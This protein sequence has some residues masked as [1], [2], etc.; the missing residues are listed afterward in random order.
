MSARRSSI[1][2]ALNPLWAKSPVVLLRFPGLLMSLTAGTMLL[3]LA[4]GSYPLFISSTSSEALDRQIESVTVF[5]AG[6]SVQ[7]D[8]LLV[9]SRA[10]YG[11]IVT[12]PAALEQYRERERA[13]AAEVAASPHL[14]PVVSSWRAPVVNGVPIGEGGRPGATR[15]FRPLYR[16]DALDHVV[17]VTGREGDGVWMADLAARDLGIRPGDELRLTAFGVENEVTVT[18]DGIYEALFN[19]ALTPYW[20]SHVQDIYPPDP[21]APAPP[22]LLLG[23]L[24]TIIH[25]SSKLSAESVVQR[26]EVPIEPGGSITLDDARDVESLSR[27]FQ[28]N[29]RDETT[30]L[31]SAF[32]FECFGGGPD[33]SSFISAIVASTEKRVA[34]V[35]GPVRLLLVAGVL[36][37]IVVVAAAGAFAVAARRVEADLLFVRG[38]SPGTM[39]MK[40]VAEAV[41]P[42]VIG[43]AA[44]FGIALGLVQTLGPGGPVDENAVTVA[45]QA[46]A[47]S[48]PV[49]I[50]LLGLVA[51]VSFVRRSESGS[52]RLGTLARVPWELAILLLSF[53]FLSQLVRGGALVTNGTTGVTRPSVYL[54]LFPILFIAAVGSL[55]ARAFQGLLKR[56]RERSDSF[57]SGGYVAVHRLAGAPRLTVLL[58]AAAALA[59]G[60]FVHAQTIVRSLETTVDAKALLFVGSDV[61]ANIRRDLPIPDDFE[62][63]RTIVT[64]ILEAGEVSPG[65]HEVD[66][67]SVDPE[68]LSEAAYWNSQFGAGSLEELASKLGTPAGSEIPV[69]VSHG[70]LPGADTFTHMDTQVPIEVVGETVAFPGTSSR[71][72]LVVMDEAQLNAFFEEAGHPGPAS[73]ARASTELWVRGDTGD[74]VAAL[75]AFKDQPYG[76]LTAE[77]VKDIPS[78]SAAIDTFGVLNILGLGAGLL[79]VVVILMYLQARQRARVVSYALSRRMGLS[80]SSH[81]LGLVIEIA[82]LLGAAYVVGSML[83]LASARFIV[84]MID[85][86]AAIPPPSLFT[87]P[88][89]LIIG[90]LGLLVAI[91]FG[92]GALTNARAKRADFAEV[93]RLAD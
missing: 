78:I 50:L 77:Q 56:V 38:M 17:R 34:P 45:W 81:R 15:Q 60:I 25:V 87:P 8:S 26:F 88:I 64:R 3:A 73:G 68:T 70:S 57:G 22:T 65:S 86:L 10:R 20:R 21:N 93:M 36:V 6:L 71:R 84:G 59:L 85:P 63:P 14:A 44:G 5:G 91:S 43:A 33:T 13:I 72:P 40:S 41:I 92:G 7:K 32:C 27:T 23:D 75:G 48:V 30:R 52:E 51:A 11:E 61:Q 49:S 89:L 58:F 47:I 12:E 42:S 83:A 39:A 2:T 16:T 76:V 79:V 69:I 80:D 35:Q 18:V 54:L 31:G 28:R 19:H 82:V 53:F 66:V 29:L 67:L 62:F 90:A 9:P 74:I 1:R 55:A 46:A 4:A 24:E 37:A